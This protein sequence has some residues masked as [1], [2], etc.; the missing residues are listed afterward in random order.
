MTISLYTCLL[1]GFLYF[2]SVACTSFNAK[3]VQY[4]RYW[5]I[6]PMSYIKSSSELTT[7]GMAG[8]VFVQHSTI[9]FI[10]LLAF[11]GTGGWTG[12]FAGMLAQAWLVKVLYK[13]PVK[14]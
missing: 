10:V 7:I 9:D 1:G 11:I 5:L 14:V 8:V 12:S 4:N 2:I 13:E 6:P 3:C